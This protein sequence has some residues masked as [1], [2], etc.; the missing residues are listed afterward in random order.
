MLRHASKAMAHNIIAYGPTRCL[1][2]ELSW[3]TM[4][5]SGGLGHPT[6]KICKARPLKARSVVRIVRPS[7]C[8]NSLQGKA[9]CLIRFYNVLDSFNRAL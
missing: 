1:P 6:Q 8:R 3:S 7:K 4:G 2:P 5:W 9:S